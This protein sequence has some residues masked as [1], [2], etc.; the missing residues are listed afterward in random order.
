MCVAE[1]N[2][3]AGV[4]DMSASGCIVGLVAS[5]FVFL[6]AMSSRAWAVASGARRASWWCNRDPC[7]AFLVAAKEETPFDWAKAWQVDVPFARP[8][9]PDTGE[10]QAAVR[11]RGETGGS[12]SGRVE[13][14]RYQSG[15]P[16][17]FIT[18]QTASLIQLYLWNEGG[19][20]SFIFH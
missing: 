20:L 12:R 7:P 6:V 17:T 8:A 3:S 5:L 9:L 10:V 16:T 11:G 1:G 18:K 14:M 19:A 4:G 15:T 2:V 13:T